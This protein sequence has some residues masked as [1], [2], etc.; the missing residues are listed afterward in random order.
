MGNDSNMRP[1]APAGVGN[2]PV[3]ATAGT[4]APEPAT[5]AAAGAASGSSA[6]TGAPDDG[7]VILDANAVHQIALSLS[8]HDGKRLAFGAAGHQ[9]QLA[10]PLASTDLAQAH[11]AGV[12][13]PATYERY[14]CTVSAG[15]FGPYYGLIAPHEWLQPLVLSGI[16]APSRLPDGHDETAC[17]ALA[18]TV[19]PWPGAIPLCAMGCGYTALLVVNGPAF[20]QVWLDARA[21]GLVAPIAPSFES[22][23]RDGLARLAAGQLPLGYVPGGACALPQALAGYLA[24]CEQKHG[25]AP[26][27]LTP[28]AVQDA[29]AGLGP[30]A[31]VISA[32]IATPLTAV[33]TVVW[34]CVVCAQLIDH[35]GGQGLRRNALAQPPRDVR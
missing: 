28:T 32:A 4:G 11:A 31:I 25:V 23:W 9:Y 3:A 8:R 34:P 12:R 19:D 18:P 14:L 10:P 24:H 20:G 35:L 29:L 16:C 2:P 26:G 1:T 33:D 15:G 6:A 22:F 21:V 30:S 5:V 27:A 17:A 7:T 13:L